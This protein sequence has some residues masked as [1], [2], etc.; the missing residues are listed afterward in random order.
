[1]AN[2]ELCERM[3]LVAL[4]D[5]AHHKFSQSREN[6]KLYPEFIDHPDNIMYLCYD[7]HLNKSIPKWSE[8]YF[9]MHF[10]IKPRSISGMELSKKFDPWWGE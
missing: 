9:C 5:H 10:E 8:I 1:M 6:R 2:C 4:A 7:H 3:G